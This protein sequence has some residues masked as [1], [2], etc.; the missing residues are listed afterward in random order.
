MSTDTPTTEVPV[1]EPAHPPIPIGVGSKVTLAGIIAAV[2]TFLTSATTTKH[3]ISDPATISYGI[4]VAALVAVFYGGRSI[5]A[6]GAIEKTLEI[7]ARVTGGVNQFSEVYASGE[8]PKSVTDPPINDATQD[9]STN[10][11]PG[12]EPLV[13]PSDP[14]P[15]VA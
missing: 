13:P 7:A 3:G 5:Q 10:V 14:P 15:P 6:K 9:P 12:G 2:A 8:W 11:G 1:P 4:A